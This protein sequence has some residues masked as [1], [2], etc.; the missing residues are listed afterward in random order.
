MMSNPSLLIKLRNFFFALPSEAPQVREASVKV[1]KALAII[2]YDNYQ[3]LNQLKNML[4]LHSQHAELPFDIG[5]FQD[6]FDESTPDGVDAY[7]QTAADAL[8]FVDQRR[9]IRQDKHLGEHAHRNV[10]EK[11]LYEELGYDVLLVLDQIDI[12]AGF[13]ESLAALA[14]RF[15]LHP[16]VAG[17]TVAPEYQP[18][19]VNLA[20]GAQLVAQNRKAW[21][22]TRGLMAAYDSLFERPMEPYQRDVLVAWWFK[23]LGFSSAQVTRAQALEAAYAGLGLVQ[24]SVNPGDALPP[25]MEMTLTELSMQTLARYVAD[26]QNFDFSGFEARVSNGNVHVDVN[27]LV[28]VDRTSVYDLFAAYKLFLKR[29]PENFS[30]VENRVGAPIE[31]L[32]KDFLV[33]G[34]FLAQDV[35]WPA[36]L[37]AAT[38]VIDLNKAKQEALAQQKAQAPIAAETQPAIAE[39]E[40]PT[41]TAVE[42]V[43]EGLF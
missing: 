20:E 29:L 7:N 27:A 24:V 17:F 22:K 21:Q 43:K 5:I 41:A 13:F 16:K 4:S 37:E 32:F 30:V 39:A 12:P 35:Y 2:V 33:S 38:K 8:K 18:E 26:P 34:E 19:V 42:A 9:F 28:P 11:F 1:K 40:T 36:I 6:G 31:L 14:D 10:V 15:A 3:Q 25:L 23:S